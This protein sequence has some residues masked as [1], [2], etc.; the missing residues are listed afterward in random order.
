MEVLTPLPHLSLPP[1]H[2]PLS[3]T[4]FTFPRSRPE[5]IFSHTDTHHAE[6]GRKIICEKKDGFRRSVT[7]LA[8]YTGCPINEKKTF[9]PQFGN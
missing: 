1:P 9:F 6:Y 3:S 2:L 7:L 8:H 5:G 4:H